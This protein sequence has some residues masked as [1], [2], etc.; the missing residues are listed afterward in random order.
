MSLFQAL[1][2]VHRTY[3]PGENQ[4]KAHKV[5]LQRMPVGELKQLA[6]MPCPI[7]GDAPGNKVDLEIVGAALRLREQMN[8]KAETACGVC[9]FKGSCKF[10]N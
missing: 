9:A 4:I 7:E 6:E 1:N 3:L 2:S 10:A 5:L 8:V